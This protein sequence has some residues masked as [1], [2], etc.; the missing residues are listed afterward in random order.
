[1]LLI[2]MTIA[3]QQTTF[4]SGVNVVTLDVTAVDKDGKPVRGL[5]A[6]D[7]VVT[8]EGQPRA[9]QTVD[10]IEFGSGSSATTAAPTPTAT[11]APATSAATRA[12]Q[13]ERRAVVMLFDDLSLKPGE[14]KGLAV[15]AQRTLAQFGPEDFVGVAV[16]SGLVPAVNPTADRTRVEAAIGKLVGRASDA[17][18]FFFSVTEADEIDRDF[19]KTTLVDVS[20]R[21]CRV[22][23]RPTEICRQQVRASA[24]M[25]AT[26]LKYRAAQQI[27]AYRSSIAAVKP[28]RGAKVVIALSGG[29][30]TPVQREL[31]QKQ[32]EG[33]MRDAAESGVRF[34][35]MNE[36]PDY[37]DAS[38]QSGPEKGDTFR[39]RNRVRID[40]ARVMFDGL[41]SVA[42]AAGGEAFHVIGQADRFFTRIEAET[43]A[44]YRLAVDAPTGADKLRFLNA[45]VSVKRAGVTV[46]A[47]RKALSTTA[48]VE[49]IPIDQQLREALALGGADLAV[50][51][52]IGTAVR[53]DAQSAQLQLGVSVQVPADTAGPVMTM[54]TLVDEAGN[55]VPAASGRKELRAAAGQEYRFSFP[56]VVASGKYSLRVVAADAN[57]RVGSAEAAVN[58]TLGRIGSYASSQMLLGWSAADG[59]Q[60]LLAFDTLPS[61]ATTLE[62]SIEM[63]DV[64]TQA[65]D[66]SVRFA[67]AKADQSQAISTAT[68]QPSANGSIVSMAHRF[69]V[70]DLEPGAYSITATVV[71]SG[72][73]LGSITSLVRKR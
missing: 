54:F 70:K 20:A 50:P 49:A 69:A 55:S 47:N 25:Y 53:R 26:E 37:S 73:E 30:P 65:S 36:E 42:I 58:A 21:E 17:W 23:N 57:G 64:S 40:N 29:I 34:Y 18:P 33:V 11:G 2:G 35:G 10:F 6:A 67:L 48:P 71:A 61:E 72:V 31:L 24:K 38:I 28:F 39:D 41:A 19:P 7:F 45:K 4:R 62:A 3:A 60:R 8:L 43:S 22:L 12:P 46:R 51:I 27:E 13:H 5:T 9:V 16:T 15:A 63:Y 52:S 44:I 14:G 1:M 68:V 56:L 59:A 32:L 66:L